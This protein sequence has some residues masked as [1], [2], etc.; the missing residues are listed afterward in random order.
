M[1]NKDAASDEVNENL[2]K[3]SSRVGEALN[4]DAASDEVHAN[5]EKKARSRVGEA[6]NKDAASDRGVAEADEKGCYGTVTR[7]MFIS[8]SRDE[9]GFEQWKNGLRVAEREM[10]NVGQAQ[11]TA[12][13]IP[14]ELWQQRPNQ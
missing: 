2:E 1:L 5:L 12:V 4:K 6:L 3:A 13:Y 11:Y 14:L 10:A 7:C 9:E 8:S